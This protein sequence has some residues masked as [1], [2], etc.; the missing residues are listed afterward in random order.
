MRAVYRQDTGFCDAIKNPQPD[1]LRLAN[2]SAG[3]CEE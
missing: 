2:L 1:G 3:L